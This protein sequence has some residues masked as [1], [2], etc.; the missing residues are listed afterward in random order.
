MSLSDFFENVNLDLV[1]G[2]TVRGQSATY[3]VPVT[4]YLAVATAAP[5]DAT[6]GTTIVEPTSGQYVGYARLAIANTASNF[7]VASASNKT[8]ANALTL[9]T[10]TGGTGATIQ[11]FAL[12]DALTL[13]NMICWGTMGAAKVVTSGITPQFA[14]G[15]L[16]FSQN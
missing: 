8:H 14:P 11:W 13:G 16:V 10:S 3:T 2:P 7:P 4:V 5:T 12:L 6:T 9:P 15:A 1:L